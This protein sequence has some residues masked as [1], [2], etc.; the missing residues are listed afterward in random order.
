MTGCTLEPAMTTNI[1]LGRFPSAPDQ[2]RR[3]GLAGAA[4]CVAFPAADMVAVR[5]AV[6]ECLF[7][8]LW[9]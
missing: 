6:Y 1:A 8:V 4:G 3:L 9:C 7:A 2:S 5:A